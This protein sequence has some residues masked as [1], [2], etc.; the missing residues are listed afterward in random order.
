MAGYARCADLPVKSRPAR[1]DPT[2]GKIAKQNAEKHDLLHELEVTKIKGEIKKEK[3]SLEPPKM[4]SLQ[5]KYRE[6]VKN[7]DDA[8]KLKALIDEE[9][10]NDPVERAKRHAIVDAL[11][12]ENL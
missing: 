2:A 4:K 3:A 8:Q 7:D 5:D 11:M 10:N 6:T 1:P 12:R 9:C